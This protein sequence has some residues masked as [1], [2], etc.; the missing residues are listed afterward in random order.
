MNIKRLPIVIGL[1]C[2]GCAEMQPSVPVYPYM[3][4]LKHKDVATPAL[5]KE[6]EAAPGQSIFRQTHALFVT[7]TKLATEAR[8]T[9][10]GLTLQVP[11]GALLA[12]GHMG[13]DKTDRY[14]TEKQ[15]LAADR[16]AKVCFDGPPSALH[17]AIL[18]FDPAKNKIS[19][20]QP[21]G[22]E[23]AEEIQPDE[24]SVS[25]EL[26]YQGFSRGTLRL[27][28]REFL[29]DMARPSFYQETTYE[30]TSF[31]AEVRFQEVA[32]RILSADNN[33]IRYQITSGFKGKEG[34]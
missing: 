15:Y 24:N 29:R 31:P 33:R 26:L 13:S 17:T 34:R 12:R 4:T 10:K 6:S 3:P 18:D 7:Q 25:K 9:Y 8:G 28:Y 1:V 32:I 23:T 16:F 20:H 5:G 2:V 21:V 30:I 22:I 14:C 11:K 27:T 19:L